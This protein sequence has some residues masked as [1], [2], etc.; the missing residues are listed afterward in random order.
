[1]SI[2][3]IIGFSKSRRSSILL[4][5]FIKCR[6]NLSKPSPR[7]WPDD[8][9]PRTTNLDDVV[10]INHHPILQKLESLRS[11]NEFDQVY[12]QILVSGLLQNSLVSGRVIKKLC[13]CFGSVSTAVLVFDSVIE[14]DAFLGNTILRCFVDLKQPFGALRFYYDKIVGRSVLC[15]HYTFPLM[16]KV[17]EEAGL[18]KDA[19]KVHAL[20]LKYGFGLDLFVRN[21]LIHM[22][23]V[24]GRVCDAEKVFDGGFMVDLVSWN[25]M[26][27][28]Y[29]KNGRMDFAREVFDE[30]PERDVFSWNTMLCG[31]VRVKDMEEARC[32]F[33]NMPAP[34]AVSWNCMIDGYAAVGDVKMAREFFDRMPRRNVV[35]W[36][37][38]LALYV[39]MKDY[40]ECI[41]LYEV[42]I[43]KG[44][45][46]KPNKA[47][48]MSVLT[49]CGYLGRIELGK[50]I[51]SYVRSSKIRPDMLLSTALLTMYAK[52]GEMDMAREVFDGMKE[53][54]IVSWNSMIIGY[55]TQGN[56]EKAIEMLIDLEKHGNVFPNGATLVCVLSACAN[57]GMVLEGWWAYDRLT[58]IYNVEPKLE[59]H[60]CLVTLLGQAGLTKNSEEL[61]EN[62]TFVLSSRWT[63]SNP[64]I[65]EILAKRLMRLQPNDIAPYVLLSYIYAV[66]GKWEEVEKVRKMIDEKKLCIAASNSTCMTSVIYSM[67]CEIGSELKIMK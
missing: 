33:E 66:D 8:P 29:V 36:N 61:K 43:D 52:C 24:C 40:T 1:M 4:E 10:D 47:S 63:L 41:R 22:Y 37:T 54:S 14:P 9:K 48:I 38:V 19:E 13:T 67:L 5:K 18:V 3:N 49:A 25:L 39:R 23:L 59:H 21:S 12:P 20:V 15:N 62:S 58:R 2:M 35:S 30:M 34:D 65:G 28:G 50:Q 7:L 32:L 60:G 51:H 44:D 6:D 17:C 64:N 42:M 57:A 26:I 53:R 55:G 45:G 56:G 27:D 31:Y 16:V 46:L 11:V